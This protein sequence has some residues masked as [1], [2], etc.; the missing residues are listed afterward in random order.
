MSADHREIPFRV[1][2]QEPTH[3]HASSLTVGILACGLACRR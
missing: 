2:G 3:L 1:K